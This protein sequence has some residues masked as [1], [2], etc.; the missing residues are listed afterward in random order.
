M[1]TAREREERL[2]AAFIELTDTLVDD[3]D[4]M[5]YLHLLADH[6]VALLDLA[7]TGV[8][9][10]DPEGRLVDATASNEATRRLELVQIESEEGPC[11][12]C[13]QSGDAT[14][15]TSLDNPGTHARWPRFAPLAREQGFTGV[16]GVPMRLRGQ[17]VGVLNLFHTGPESLQDS[18]LRLAQALGDAATIGILTQRTVHDQALLA[19]QMHHAL[20]SRIVIEQAK[21]MLAERAHI[22]VDEAFARLRHHARQR[23]LRLTTLATRVIENGLVIP[24]AL[25]PDSPP[26]GR[27]VRGM[28]AGAERG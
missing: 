25:E 28:T 27:G 6:A 2:A 12:D 22:S 7:A 9:L 3:F 14:P 21:G 8:I 5:E 11:W 17:L 1:G 20:E 19:D 15:D 23:Q 18:T 24:A 4:V 13:A 26:P 10:I 16:A